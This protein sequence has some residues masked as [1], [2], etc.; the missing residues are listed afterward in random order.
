MACDNQGHTVCFVVFCDEWEMQTHGKPAL[1]VWKCGTDLREVTGTG[2]A[3]CW[4]QTLSLSY[5]L[6]RDHQHIFGQ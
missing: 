6:Q 1:P 5:A 4:G 2:V 3:Q